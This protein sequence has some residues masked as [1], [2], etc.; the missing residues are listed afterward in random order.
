MAD[1]QAEEQNLEP[2]NESLEDTISSEVIKELEEGEERQ[3][4][5]PTAEEGVS[6][7]P[8]EEQKLREGE[9][10]ESMESTSETSDIEE[11][12]VSSK[13]ELKQPT[14]PDHEFSAKID[15]EGDIN[16]AQTPTLPSQSQE[17]AK[18]EASEASAIEEAPNEE[19]KPL[20]E[21]GKSV[22]PSEGDTI[23]TNKNESGEK[24]D[25]LTTEKSNEIPT[26]DTS[27]DNVYGGGEE[28]GS[29][30]GS[31][32]TAEGTEGEELSGSDEEG[33]P[34]EPQRRRR[35][36]QDDSELSGEEDIEGEGEA[37]KGGEVREGEYDGE[38]M[39]QKLRLKTVS[40]NYEI[41]YNILWYICCD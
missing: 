22:E 33:E 12:D 15:S 28:E 32:A 4:A 41:L 1:I 24:V 26:E 23:D 2:Q 31:F 29:D 3:V 14:G 30:D 9:E 8:Q 10:R 18:D 6:T 7:S 5:E 35:G 27:K 40:V 20:E 16:E 36:K 11:E 25:T 17:S 13:E 39:L 38:L 19:Q 21:E 34:R 37:G